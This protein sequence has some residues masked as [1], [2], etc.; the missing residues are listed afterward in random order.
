MQLSGEQV[1]RIAAKKAEAV[2]RKAAKM[3]Q[4]LQQKRPQQQWQPMDLSAT[5]DGVVTQL[6]AT[7]PRGGGRDVITKKRKQG[8]QPADGAAPMWPNGPQSSQHCWT[9]PN[10]ASLSL[11]D[12]THRKP[13]WWAVDTINP[14]AWAAGADYMARSAADVILTQEVKVPAGDP[15]EAG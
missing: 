14:N 3:E 5:A 6:S 7:G 12:D 10:D 15:C 2:K 4:Q 8:R 13:G 9:W 11:T 1:D